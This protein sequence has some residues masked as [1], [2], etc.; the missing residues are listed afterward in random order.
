MTE[1][2][3]FAIAGFGA[4]LALIGIA[5]LIFGNIDGIILIFVGTLMVYGG[6]RDTRTKPATY[7]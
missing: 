6:I 7:L 5:K 2:S 4:I 3:G 1:F